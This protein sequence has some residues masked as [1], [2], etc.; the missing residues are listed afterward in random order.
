MKRLKPS[1]FEEITLTSGMRVQ[2]PKCNLIFKKWE[3]RPI[4][5]TYNN[6]AVIDVN[7]QPLFAEL[8]ILKMFKKDGWSGVWVDSYRNKYRIGLP[9]KVAPIDL[10]IAQEKLIQT[11]KKKTRKRGGCWDVFVWKGKKIMFAEAK[12]HKKDNI[13]PNQISWLESSLK[14]GVPLNSFIFV[15]WDLLK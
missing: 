2:I 3:G 14:I 7:R 15:E 11:I 8:A 5:D 12:R 6:K 10:P 1:S 9:E 13:K 4:E